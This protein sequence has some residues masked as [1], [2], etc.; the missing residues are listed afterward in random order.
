MVFSVAIEFKV[1][2]FNWLSLVTDIFGVFAIVA[3]YDLYLVTTPYA[4]FAF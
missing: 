3:W 2:L 4:L 1:F